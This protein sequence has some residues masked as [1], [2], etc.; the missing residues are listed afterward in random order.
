MRSGMVFRIANSK[1]IFCTIKI[2]I[3]LSNFSM[4][5]LGGVGT[6]HRK[7]YKFLKLLSYLKN[8]LKLP[9]YLHLFE[10]NMARSLVYTNL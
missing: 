8:I 3:F 5:V 4:Y 1:W 10:S 2:L 7:W 9:I 6:S